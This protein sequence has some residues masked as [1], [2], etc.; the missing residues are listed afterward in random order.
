MFTKCNK[1]DYLQEYKSEEVV[2][3][4]DEK[5]ME[6][7]LQRPVRQRMKSYAKTET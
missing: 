3:K 7:L 2:S 4:C 1:T 6:L 5:A